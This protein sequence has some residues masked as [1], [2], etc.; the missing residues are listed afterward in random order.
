MNS[1]K[2]IMDMIATETAEETPIMK[3]PNLPPI[4]Y[5]YQVIELPDGSYEEIE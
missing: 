5:R 4:H 1:L 3:D 2:D